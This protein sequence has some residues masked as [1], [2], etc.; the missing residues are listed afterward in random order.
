MIKFTAI[1][2]VKS[3]FK[4]PAG[5]EE[6]KNNESIIEIEAQYKD[7]L[8]KIE[9]YEYLQIVYYLH[10]TEGYDLISEWRVGP[11]RGVFS[12]RSPRRPNPIG[13]TTVKLLKK[14]DNKL[15]VYGLDAVDGTP[16][17]DIKVHSELMDETSSLATDL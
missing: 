3:K 16:V 4:K 1:G 10:Q 11:R 12:S 8:Y 15:F 6:M 2:K 14:E 5:P 9:D 7:G 17:L 13:V